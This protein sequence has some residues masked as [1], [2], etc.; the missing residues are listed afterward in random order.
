MSSRRAWAKLA[1]TAASPAIASSRHSHPR[2][3][4]P[5]QP[6]DSL[7]SRPDSFRRLF[8]YACSAS[9][10]NRAHQVSAQNGAP[11]MGWH[12][13]ARML[14][15]SRRALEELRE[16]LRSLSIPVSTSDQM[17]INSIPYA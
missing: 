10:L 16:H 1:W 14:T 8:A 3:T 12:R 17:P 6:S 13:S 4:S 5:A 2:S 7:P 11:R 15:T 9:D